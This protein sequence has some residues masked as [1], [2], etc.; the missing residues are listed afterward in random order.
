MSF[1]VPGAIVSCAGVDLRVRSID[2][3]VL[4]LESFD[5][6]YYGHRHVSSCSPAAHQAVPSVV[7]HRRSVSGAGRYRSARMGGRS[8]VRLVGVATGRRSPMRDSLMPSRTAALITRY[9]I[10]MPRMVVINAS[11][12]Q[13]TIVVSNRLASPPAFV[14]CVFLSAR[15]VLG[16]GC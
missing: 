9:A 14:I 4:V 2:G 1:C 6:S 13:K 7:A 8:S 15:M 3:R 16:S 5:G 11:A 12:P 10:Q